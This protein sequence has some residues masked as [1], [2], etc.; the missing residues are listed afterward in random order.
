MTINHIHALPPG[1]YLEEYRLDAVLGAGGFGITY[2][3]YDAHLDKSI[4][5]KEFLPRDIATRTEGITVAP[6]SGADARDYNWGLE[7]F[8]DEA[9]KLARFKHPHLNEVYRF[10]KANGTA[11]MVLEYI[12][13]E[14]L[15]ERLNR[16]MR[17]S[18]QALRQLL[19]EMLSG[20]AVVH[21]ANYVHRDIK[22]DNLILREEDGSAVL[23]DFGAARQAVGERSQSIAVIL[24]PPY[25]PMEQYVGKVG[26]I[27]PWTDVYALGMV[28]YRCISGLGRDD[29]PDGPER[30][31][32]QHDDSMDLTPAVEVGKGSYT[33]QLLETIDWAIEV[34]SDA[35]PQEAEEWRQALAG[36]GRVKRPYKPKS[37]ETGVPPETGVRDWTSIALVALLVALLGTG[38][39]WGWD[40]WFNPGPDDDNAGVIVDYMDSFSVALENENIDGARSYLAT[41]REL[42]PDSPALVNME[43]RLDL[44]IRAREAQSEVTR[45]LNEAE[46]FLEASRG[47]NAWAKYERVLELQPA[48]EVAKAGKVRV[49]ESYMDSF[50]EALER[51]QFNNA[52]D[53]LATIRELQPDSPALANMEQSL[54][55]AIGSREDSLAVGSEMTRLLREAEEDMEAL[56]LTT[57]P[58]NNAWEKYQRVSELEPANQDAIAGKARVIGSYMDLFGEALERQQF[59]NADGYLATIRELQPDSPMLRDG[60]Q[61]LEEARQEWIERIAGEM[62]P[63]TGGTFHMGNLK[64]DGVIRDEGKDEEPPH[65]VTVPDFKLGKYEVTIVQ[66]RNF[67][68]ATGYK[69][70][71]ETGAGGNP[72]CKI[73]ITNGFQWTAGSSWKNPGYAIEDNQPVVCVGWNDVQAFITW[74]SAQTGET[75]RLPSEAEWEYAVRAETTTL[76]HFGNDEREL[77]SYANHADNNTDFRQRN[78]TCSDGVGERAAVVGKYEPNSYDLYDMHGNVYEWVQDCY[79][80]TYNGAP[81]NG[82]AWTNGNCNQR[83]IRGGSYRNNPL[84]LRSANRH[85]RKLSDIYYDLGFRLAQDQ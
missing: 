68:Q 19:M 12:H 56:R 69:T 28:A 18:E 8:L 52:D 77:C 65:P 76:Y 14:T 21:K 73:Y 75:F 48:N 57:P 53:Y 39:W 44:A 80:K 64:D 6:L 5:I 58:G 42:Q 16:D 43:Q 23:L 60:E 71:A 38:A 34:D 1:T 78:E 29:I 37:P 54:D 61:R 67:V 9:R 20:L 55:L 84:R 81:S 22:P 50:G 83:V 74:L 32:V 15:E 35:R 13:G 4:A 3:A 27:G 7:E 25:A 62:V 26:H 72:G 79:N 41:I 31:L 10:F 36:D 82:S 33:P 47:S 85:N 51:Q 40:K 70:N 17:L 63:I 24:T 45:L 2:L 46:E 11:Y 30:K 66:F 49:I 59:N